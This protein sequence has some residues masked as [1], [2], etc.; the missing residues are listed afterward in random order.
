MEMIRLIIF[1]AGGVL[2]A[3]SQKIVDEAVKRFLKKHGVYDFD[4]SDRIW[5]RIEKLVSVG[6][7]S[8]T[9]AHERWLKGVGLRKDLLSE[10]LEIDR[11]QIWSRFRR[12]PRI[13]K[14]LTRLKKDYMLAVLSDTIDSK[15]EKI[16]KMEIVGVDHRVFDDIFTS[17]DLGACKPSK[18][19]FC[20]ILEKFHFKPGEAV[21][22]SDASDELRGAKRIGLVT[23]GFNSI[24]G[25][26]NVKRLDEIPHIL[27]NLNPIGE[28]KRKNSR[29]NTHRAAAQF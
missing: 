22:V 16:E 13:N 5:S 28:F 12:T 21:F 26:Y 14:L 23:I 10:W 7:I 9:E 2:Y 20:T 27:Q 6:K 15:S 1:D 19:V 11:K 17:H 4:K 3:G 24:G 25:E 8:A 29:S 18:K